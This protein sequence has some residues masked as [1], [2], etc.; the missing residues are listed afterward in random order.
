MVVLALLAFTTRSYRTLS[1]EYQE[2]EPA[3]EQVSAEELPAER[4]ES[5]R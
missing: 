1:A 5:R 2:E 4:S 3:G